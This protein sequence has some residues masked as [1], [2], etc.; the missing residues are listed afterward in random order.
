MQFD[1]QASSTL[2]RLAWCAQMNRGRHTV[3]V[4]CGPWVETRKKCFFEGAW[5][6]SLAE[7]RPDEAITQV[8]TAG[9]VASES[10]IFSTSTNLHDRLYF[11][12]QEDSLWVSNSLAFI[13]V[14]AGDEPDP[15]F[16]YYSGEWLS[17]VLAGIRR[18]KRSL[19]LR[20]GE[21]IM[22]ECANLTVG[23][24]LEVR[25]SEKNIPPRPESYRDY[26]ELLSAS[27]AGVF[28]N[29][30]HPDRNQDYLPLA[31]L[32][33]GYDATAVAAL[34]QGLGCNEAVTFKDESE[35]QLK[36]DSGRIIGEELG[37]E[38]FEF[39]RGAYAMSP[40]T[41]E[42][43]FCMMPWG[44]D[45]VFASMESIL[46]GRI[47]LTGRYGDDI[48]SLNSR[49]LVPDLKQFSQGGMAGSMLNEFRLRV[50]FHNFPPLFAGWQHV[51]AVHQISRGEDMKE[52]S[53][54]GQYD[55]PVARRMIEEVGVPRE[56]FGNIKMA[57]GV[58]AV[59]DAND[60]CQASQTDYQEFL[61]Q[62]TLRSRSWVHVGFLHWA[63]RTLKSINR[64]IARWTRA[65]GKPL[66]PMPRLHPRHWRNPDETRLLHW[67][68]SR[69]RDR[70]R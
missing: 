29:A 69:I 63:D 3:L 70:Y 14:E 40:G 10:V 12:R 1:F 26:V 51:E 48:L 67:G 36:Q 31:T 59:S 17:Q 45:V 65:L 46:P 28:E 32:S 6:G 21:V 54:G 19:P 20:R 34:A 27:M 9:R 22:H 52:W 5:D 23:L 42:A 4:R 43:E 50:G 35:E 61:G 41:P 56:L 25:R 47:L 24:D 16:P 11:Y 55:R 30:R 18:E 49:Y 68:F 15:G 39:E 66:Y 60:L 7:E 8:G 58:Q 37:M 64:S 53:I 38:V 44:G 2:P 57:G 13:L 62:S 33:R